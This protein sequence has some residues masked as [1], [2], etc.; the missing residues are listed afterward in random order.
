[1]VS[2]ANFSLLI[3]TFFRYFHL[4]FF[5]CFITLF[6]HSTPFFLMILTPIF[7]SIY[8]YNFCSLFN[9]SL[10]TFYSSLFTIYLLAVLAVRLHQPS[11]SHSTY[12]F[13]F[14]LRNLCITVLIYFFFPFSFLTCLYTSYSV[15][16]NF[17]LSIQLFALLSLSFYSLVSA[18]P[19][20]HHF[21][22]LFSLFTC[23]LIFFSIFSIQFL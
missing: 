16:L 8:F 14:F 20:L 4:L 9:P 2:C 12:I 7:P 19:F 15:C 17:F 11:L 13:Y 22:T 3:S 18:C 21:L 10:S 23:S 1:M 6:S 5:L